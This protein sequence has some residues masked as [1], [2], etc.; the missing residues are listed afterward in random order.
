MKSDAP[1]SGTLLPLRS[2][3]VA[4]SV[5]RETSSEICA[6]SVETVE[7]EALLAESIA[8]VRTDHPDVR[9]EQEVVVVA[10]AQCLVDA[11]AGASMVVVGSRG[12]GFFSGMLLGSVSQAVLHGATCPVAV[13]R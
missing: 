5:T 9:L 6:S 8:G 1:R 2:E 11:S 12:L 13:V 4:T 3:T 10:P 7:R